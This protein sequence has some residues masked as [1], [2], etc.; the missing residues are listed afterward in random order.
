[1]V[2]VPLSTNLSP[3]TFKTHQ[4]K[5]K[6]KKKKKKLITSSNLLQHPQPNDPINLRPS[7]PSS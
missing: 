5:K 3:L 4:K 2:H 6:K 7:K 1:M